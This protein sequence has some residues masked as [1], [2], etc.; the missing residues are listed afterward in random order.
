MR[1]PMTT[2]YYRLLFEEKLGFELAGRF[3]SFP[4]IFGIEFDDTG[5]EEAFSVYDHPEVRIYRKT[6]DYSEAT[7]RSYFDPIDLENTLMMWP[8]QVSQ[9]P[10]A[11]Y[12]TPEEA[13]Q[14]QA[15]GTWSA[16]FDLASLVN[17]SQVVAVIVWLLLLAVLG[18]AAF[19]FAFV[20]FRR[21]ADRG[22]GVSKTL[23]LLLLAWLSWLGPSLK[24]VPF[25]Q[26]W[27]A[28]ALGLLIGLSGVVAWRTRAALRQFVR[29]RGALLL[30]EEAVFLVLFGLFLLIRIGNPDLWHPARGGEKPMEFAY[31]NAIIRSTH[32]PPY[33]P[34]HAGGY[35]NYYYFGWVMV[36][37]LTKLTGIV[38][39]VAY[40]LAVPTLFGLT[41]LGAFAAAFNL[42][43]GDH[44]TVLPGEEPAY[45]GMRIGPVLAGLA[46]VFFVVIIG[47][48]GN[49]K[50]LYEQLILRA[51]AGASAEGALSRVLAALSGLAAVVAGR[52]KLDF[53]NDWWFWNASRVIPDTINEFP[54]FTF[55]YADLHA[56]MLALPLTL[57]ALA[58]IVALVRLVE[59]HPHAALRN[60]EP[61]PWYIPLAQLLP[62]ALVGFVVGA[63]RATNT[64]DF[65]TYTLAALAAIVVVEGVRRQRMVRPA[66][67]TGWLG[68][69]FRAAVSV[70]WRVALLV[71]I[72]SVTFYPYTSHYATAYAGLQLWNE[73]RTQLPD[74][75]VMWGFFLVLVVV[76][77]AA[78]LIS[79]RRDRSLP[80]WLDAALPF[81]AG[82]LV[83]VLA[84]GLFLKIQVW[85][86]ALP[87]FALAA[88]LGLGRDIPP[89]RRFALL[90][91]ALALAITMGVELVRQKDDIGRM[92]TVFKFYLQAWVIFGAATAFGLATWLPRA[93]AWRPGWRRAVAVVLLVLFAGTMFYPPFA[94]RAKVRDRFSAEAS[95]RGLDGMAYME[96]AQYSD[97]GR[98]L[99]LADDRQAMLWLLQNVEG[100]PVILEAQ[101]PEYRWGSRFAN[102][103]GLPTVQGWNW[104]QRQQRSVV[105]SMAVERRVAHVQELY[106]TT[107]LARTGRLLALYGV[108]YIIVGELERAYYSPEGLAK[109]D[110]LVQAGML[111]VAHQAGAVT[112]YRVAGSLASAT[113]VPAGIGPRP[114]PTPTPRTGTFLSP[115]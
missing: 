60:A 72:A 83:L 39:W 25:A 30:T 40:N 18:V 106:S 79:Q 3:T 33:D 56:H 11:L 95:P 14:Q 74:Y 28:L 35:I 105:P 86:L 82:A 45:Q 57:L 98:D 64:W 36:A 4:T 19:P 90:L 10:T 2:E 20:I 96:R 27:I 63:L 100:S 65:P 70:V 37:V 68:F 52:A 8:K 113:G 6:A 16:M 93:F 51:S 13:A 115:Q 110:A 80:G 75:F 89:A 77:L 23:G 21:L 34:W 44:A 43:D 38:P 97:N 59:W 48:L 15:G 55:T 104:H 92:N 50:L 58:G 76:Q 107:D 102:Y 41:G 112:I 46:G 42:A 73:A 47:N 66:N 22:Y 101:I 81:V 29:D 71:A 61:S 108:R 109:F 78:E 24:A 32:F 67:L 1:Y 114:V 31:L 91:L 49:V 69:L 99:R 5:A 88:I 17:R 94:A 62:L 26:W 54:F 111:E 9:A 12:L 103:T 87:L 85:L 84:F 7:V 53:P